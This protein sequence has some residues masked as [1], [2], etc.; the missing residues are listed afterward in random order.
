MTS[1]ETPILQ[2]A[3]HA[4]KNK[5]YLPKITSDLRTALTPLAV[6]SAL[7]PKVKEIYLKITGEKYRTSSTGAGFG[8]IFGGMH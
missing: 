1:E 2:K 5:E 8:M 7:S 3:A 6:K 4:L